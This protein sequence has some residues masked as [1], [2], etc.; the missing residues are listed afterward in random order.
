VGA[1]PGSYEPDDREVIAVEPSAVMASQRPDGGARV[2]RAVAGAIPLPDGRVDAAMTV[3]SMHH[4][5]PHQE[6][7]VRE[8]CRVARKQIVIVTIDPEVSGRMWLMADYLHEVADLDHQ[9]F[10]PPETVCTWL[11]RAATVEVV[12]VSRDTPDWALVSFWAHPERVLDEGA[13]NA[14]SGFARQPA[15]VVDRVVAGVARDLQSGA[16]DERHGA[17]RNLTEYDAGLRI[18]KAG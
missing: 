9:I 14:T 16:W 1:G 2:V 18:I 7:G 11:D 13:R 12:P 3:L 10:P 15:E 5:H 4:W 6:A 8:M 17:L